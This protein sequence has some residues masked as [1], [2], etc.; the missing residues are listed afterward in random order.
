M[1]L[2]SE[3]SAIMALKRDVELKLLD[4]IVVDPG[5]FGG[6]PIIKGHRLAVVH[7]LEMLAAGDT[8]ESLLAAYDFL[9]PDDIRACILYAALLVGHEHV[10]PQIIE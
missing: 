8:A 3:G 2:K 1:P 9:E 4:R 5:V 7:I 10:E 6:K